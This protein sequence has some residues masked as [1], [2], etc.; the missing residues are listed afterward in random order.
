MT[1]HDA[2]PTGSEA[3]KNLVLGGIASFTIVDGTKVAAADLGNNFFL[4]AESLG[5]PRAQSV[6]RLL[7]E[8]NEAVAGSFVEEEP[9]ALLAANP[10]FFE[11]FN[12]VIATQVPLACALLPTL[13][14]CGLLS[15]L[16]CSSAPSLSCGAAP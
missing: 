14:L 4:E 5:A 13:M 2:G 1:A 7:S 10:A 9:A 6:A 3:L 15:M 12:I 11:A 8:L 16:Y